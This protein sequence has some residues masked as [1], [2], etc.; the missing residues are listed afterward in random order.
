MT[1]RIV[2]VPASTEGI[3]MIVGGAVRIGSSSQDRQAAAILS[4]ARALNAAA[5]QLDE[6]DRLAAWLEEMADS[7]QGHVCSPPQPSGGEAS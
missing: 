6:G 1:N 5:A 3:A 2:R 7:L 4:S